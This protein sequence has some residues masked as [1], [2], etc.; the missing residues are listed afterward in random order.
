MVLNV[1]GC[2]YNEDCSGCNDAS[3]VAS[4]P[5]NLLGSL[6]DWPLRF[7]VSLVALSALLSILR[8]H[9]PFLPK[10]GMSLLEIKTDYKV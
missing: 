3:S 6:A 5:K 10:D 7:W 4:D 2:L 8:V 9:F 1:G